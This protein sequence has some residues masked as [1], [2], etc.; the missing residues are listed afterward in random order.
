MKPFFNILDVQ[1]FDY[2]LDS[3]KIQFLWG[4]VRILETGDRSK[5]NFRDLVTRYSEKLLPYDIIV[6]C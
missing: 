2:D 6:F 3:L 4:E 5:I 1:N